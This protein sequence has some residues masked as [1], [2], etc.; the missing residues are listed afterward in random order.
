MKKLLIC[1]V[2]L[3]GFFVA[4]SVHAQTLF[5]ETAYLELIP[6]NP[7]PRE[8]VE[9]SLNAYSIDMSGASI[10]WYVD[11]V[12]QP[13]SDNEYS[14]NVLVGNLG[15]TVRVVAEIYRQ[16]RP[17]LSVSKSIIAQTVD[18]IIEPQ[19]STP[20]FY[21]GKS[22]PAPDEEVRAV[23][24]PHTT[25]SETYTYTWKLGQE[26]LGGNSTR[27]RNVVTFTMPR[28]ETIL[29]VTVTD[30]TGARVG[31]R[32]IRLNPNNP[33]VYFYEENP[34]RGMRQNAVLENLT[35]PQG[36]ETTIHAGVYNLAADI[37]ES[38]AR[39]Y[40]TLNDEKITTFNDSG[41]SLTLQNSGGA[42]NV[43]VGFFA[44]NKSSLTQF[45]DDSFMLFFQ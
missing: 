23:A 2:F 43:E 39:L 4:G 37:F 45:V 6:R 11:G 32:A 15:S 31:G 7:E 13:E 19:T 22:L 14:T 25:S 38:D 28:R 42:Q 44:Q 24:V 26:V 41:R 27:G 18:L 8:F 10:T 34:L 17:S 12:R 3:V 35:L 9:V 30:A 20:F 5:G 33:E 40:W 1:F 29:S 21:K 16:G 36:S